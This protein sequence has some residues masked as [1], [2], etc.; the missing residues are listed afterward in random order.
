MTRDDEKAR[1]RGLRSSAFR[2]ASS[3]AI[4]G[5]V[6]VFF[7]DALIARLGLALHPTT[8]L[9]TLKGWLFIAV[10]T[11][12]LYALIG[13][14]LSS[15]RRSEEDLIESR[16]TL[17]TLLS[18]LPGTAYRIRNDRNETV[19][20]ISSRC[21]E[22]TGYSSDELADRKSLADMIH[23]VDRQY[24][25]DTIDCAVREMRPYRLLY[26]IITSLA[27]EKWVWEQGTGVYSPDG[28]LRFLEGFIS[29]IT[30]RKHAEDALRESEERYRALVEGTPDA[31]LMVDTGRN[32]LSVNQALL[33]L[34]GYEKAE[35]LG[36]NAIMLH[37]S[38]ESYR[39]FGEIALN[40]GRVQGPLRVEWEMRKRDGTIFPIEGSYSAIVNSDGEVVAY[41][42]IIRDI[43]ARKKAEAE[44]GRY[45]EQLEEMVIERTRDL[46]EA[47]KALVQREKLK[48]LGA[49][50]TEVAHEIRNPL[51]SIGGFARRLQKRLPDSPEAGIILSESRRLEAILDRISNYLKPVEMK[52]RECPVNRVVTDCIELLSPELTREN[53]RVNLELDPALPNAY[54]DPDILSQVLINVIRSSLAVM[55]R[56]QSLTVRSY[57]GDRTLFIDLNGPVTRGYRVKDPELLFLPFD[58]GGSSIGVSHSFKLLRG[59]GGHLT[60]VQDNETITFTLTLPKSPGEEVHGI[61]TIG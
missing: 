30:E 53:T 58:E 55:D 27:E 41:V 28:Q 10:T 35:V 51:V 5:V 1:S 17:S 7:S 36:K 25:R 46:R 42:G 26:R 14:T 33:D 24:V 20:F 11:A 23:P 43:T 3:Y 4:V 57:D 45:R 15:M 9:M 18:N 34:F 12:I 37:P 40:M 39:D 38:E 8:L 44:L 61:Y 13:R 59:M 29:D 2:I 54:V 6:W 60:V 50:S 19:E 31:I 16:R 21:Y 22:L 48:T 52:P 32:I 49:I 56:K 47:Q